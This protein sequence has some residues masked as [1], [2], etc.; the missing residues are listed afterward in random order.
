MIPGKTLKLPFTL[1]RTT[2]Q[3]DAT[4]TLGIPLQERGVDTTCRKQAGKGLADSVLPLATGKDHRGAQA[5]Q[6]TGHIR[7]SSSQ[8]VVHRPIHR[9]VTSR[10]AKPID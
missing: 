7:W 1:Q 10:R 2:D 9:R 5:D 3:H 6:A 4:G 8:T